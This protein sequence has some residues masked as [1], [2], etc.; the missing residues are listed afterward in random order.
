MY[1]V[2]HGAQGN[3]ISGNCAAGDSLNGFVLSLIVFIATRNAEADYRERSLGRRNNSMRQQWTDYR[4]FWREFRHTYQ[5]TGAVL[6]SGRALSAALCRYVR[7]DADLAAGRNGTPSAVNRPNAGRRILEVGPGTGAVTGCIVQAMQPGDRLVLVERNE[8][9]VARLRARMVDEPGFSG[10]ADRITLLHASVEELPEDQIFDLII[11]GL[12][13]NNFS[14]ELVEQIL[15]KLRRLLA[16]GGTLSFFEYVAIRRTKSLVS[17]RTERGRLRS[18]GRLMENLFHA[19]EVQR[20]LVLANVPPA[21]V[22]HLQ[23]SG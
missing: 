11:S 16:P 19:N 22:H 10:A 13:L 7:N 21:W 20:D 12:P 14:V 4:V 23:F 3:Q 2:I 9:F 1:A 5:S 15:A 18:V 8:Q 6:P 17:P